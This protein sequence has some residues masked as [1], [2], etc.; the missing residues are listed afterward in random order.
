MT[1]SVPLEARRGERGWMRAGRARR[2]DDDVR[3]TGRK[4]NRAMRPKPWSW[5][6]PI[7]PVGC[8]PIRF[9]APGRCLVADAEVLH[10]AAM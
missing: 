1:L 6:S 9:P 5:I 4:S 2:K 7:L 10:P 8:S 3:P